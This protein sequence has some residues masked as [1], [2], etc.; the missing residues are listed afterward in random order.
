MAGVILPYL[1]DRP[2]ALS[3]HP[4]GIEGKSF[5]QKDV[6]RQPPPDWVHTA[7]LSSDSGPEQTIRALL[8]QDEA[9]LIY[10]ANLGCIE[11]HPWCSRMGSLDW[12][13]YVVLDLDPED[14]AFDQVVEAARETRKVLEQAGAEGYCKT[15]GQRGLHVYVPFG[16]RY[17][18]EQAKQF[19]EL[20]VRLVH[21]RLPGS[22]SLIRQPA[23][24]QKRVYLD[25]LQNG[26]GK[27]VAA[28][29]SLRAYPGAPVS[30]P[31][32][33]TEVKRGFD[34]GRFT[35]RTLPKRLEAIGD[36]WTPVLGEGI[37]LP[38]SL[39]R[40]ATILKSASKK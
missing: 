38:A 21:T 34:P 9:T 27:T 2:L 10:L 35:M 33:W 31:L 25:Y 18:Y 11:L 16:G 36:L 40:L 14:I 13:D 30:T 6:S 37:D 23:K 26:K 12:P 20:I 5:F 8:C 19:A 32:R 4:N 1:R 39:E 3:R 28:P 15:S 29:Y 7:L 22:T 17:P 24:R